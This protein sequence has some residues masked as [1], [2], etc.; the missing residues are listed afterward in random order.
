M[1]RLLT[2]TAIVALVLGAGL[3]ALA[4]QPYQL[5]PMDEAKRDRAVAVGGGK[6]HVLPAT[7]ET[8]QW[9]WLDPNEKPK[10]GRELTEL[11]A[12]AADVQW[13]R[14]DLPPE[15]RERLR[16]FLAGRD[17][18]VTGD[19]LVL[20]TLRGR[21]RERQRFALGLPLLA[22]G[23]IVSL[24]SLRVARGPSLSA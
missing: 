16:Q 5:S 19:R 21:A 23:V 24:A 20:A 7:L 17:E 15:Q 8:T 2:V 6:Y 4:Q 3:F 18:L 10:G 13:G 9:G 11:R 1:K 12:L 14:R 22:A